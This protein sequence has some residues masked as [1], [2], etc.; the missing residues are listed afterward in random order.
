MENFHKMTQSK[1]LQTPL[2]PSKLL[3]T[4]TV[5]WYEEQRRKTLARH[6]KCQYLTVL[7]GLQINTS[8]SRVCE[9]VSYSL[10]SPPVSFS[11]PI[12]APVM[13]RMANLFMITPPPDPPRTSPTFP[14]PTLCLPFLFLNNPPS[15]VCAAHTLMSLMKSDPPSTRCHGDAMTVHSIQQP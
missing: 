6:R 12:L 14:L 15:Q 11:I 7:L 9:A 3:E 10:S 8:C 13:T 2:P 5:I 1:S 4:M